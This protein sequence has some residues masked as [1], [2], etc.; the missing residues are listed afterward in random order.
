MIYSQV[1]FLETASRRIVMGAVCFESGDIP[2]IRVDTVAANGS[3]P[4]PD[5]VLKPI[6]FAHTKIAITGELAA[7]RFLNRVENTFRSLR[8]L[9]RVHYLEVDLSGIV[10]VDE[11]GKRVLERA[12]KATQAC[13]TRVEVVAASIELN[14][15][16]AAA[17][18]RLLEAEGGR[19]P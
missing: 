4:G 10:V 8:Q 19:R 16:L 3:T 11:T 2:T 14:F 5:I 6:T 1:N 17:G 9:L 7:G 12:I 15:M 18:I 13:G